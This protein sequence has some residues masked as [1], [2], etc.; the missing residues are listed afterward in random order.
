MAL[1]KKSIQSGRSRLVLGTRAPSPAMS[2]KR[3]NSY[4][5][6]KVQIERAPHASAGEGARAPSISLS[7]PATPL[8]GQGRSASFSR[9]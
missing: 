2:A 1:L 6:K 9:S 5:V 3:E 8:F 4:S 7:L